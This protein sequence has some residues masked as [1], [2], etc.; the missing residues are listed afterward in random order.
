MADDKTA[1]VERGST[2]PPWPL[3]EAVV[4]FRVMRLIDI[5]GCGH[6][7][8]DFVCPG[9]EDGVASCA[10]CGLLAS[11]WNSERACSIVGLRN[12]TTSA[13]STLVFVDYSNREF[14]STVLASFCGEVCATAWADRFI[15]SDLD[16]PPTKEVGSGDETATACDGNLA[17]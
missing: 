6:A 3:S 2:L 16:L 8:W 12:V 4:V 1:A 13:L 15:G 11:R 9:T 7:P 17:I 10:T 14:Y 5:Y